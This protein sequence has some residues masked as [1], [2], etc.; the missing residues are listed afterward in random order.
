[1]TTD[2]YTHAHISKNNVLLRGYKDGKRYSK[3]IPYKPYMFMASN[4]RDAEFQTYNGLPAHKI[5]FDSIFEAKDFMRDNRGVAGMN[6][7]GMDRFIY[8]FLYDRFPGE[9]QYDAD[10]INVWF[11]DIETGGEGFPDIKTADHHVWAISWR[12]RDKIVALGCPP[13]GSGQDYRPRWIEGK[14]TPIEYISCA[15]ERELLETFLARW[16]DPLDGPDIVTGWNIE[17]FDIPYLVNRITNVLGNDEAKRLS[18]WR[19]L[20]EDEIES[21]GR[22]QQVYYPVGVNVLD[23]LNLY[24]KFTYNQQASYT[25]DHIAF[26][27]LGQRKLD[28]SEF[29]SLF[30][31]YKEDFNKAMEY[32]VKDTN[33]VYDIDQKMRLVELVYA[34]AYDAKVNY[35]DTLGAVNL[36][37]VIIHNYLRDRKMVVPQQYC[38]DND[39]RA[40]PG[41]FVKEPKPGMYNWPM[42]FDLTSLYPHLIMGYNISPDTFIR[43]LN[44]EF[45]VDDLVEGKH[46]PFDD[47]YDEK[48]SLT[49]NMCLYSNAKRGFL[50]ELMNLQ[51]VQRSEYKKKMLEAKK[52]YESTP[53]K[54]LKND[55]SRYDNAQMAKKIQ[56]NSAYGALANKYFRWYS[57][58][59][60]ESITLSGQLAARWIERKMNVYLNKVLETTDVD[61]VIAVDTDSIYLNLGDLVKKTMPKDSSKEDI[62]K[63]LDQV[64]K[65][66]IEGLMDKWYEE[67]HVYM[68]SYE[69]KMKMKRE[70]IAD[71]AIWTGK[72]RYIMNV[73]DNEGVRYAK[74]KLKIMGLESV[75]S[76]TPAAC[77]ERL[78][79]TIELIM[80]TDNDTV[81]DYIANFRQ[82][83]EK[84]PFDEI[85]FPRGINNIDKYY[86]PVT[87]C[88]KSCPMHVRGALVFNKLIADFKLLDKYQ[89]IVDKDKIKFAYLTLPN[90]AMQ[91]T[92][93]TP[94]H[95]PPEFE[96][97][98]SIDYEM[99]FNKAYLEPIRNIL[100]AIGWQTERFNTLEDLFG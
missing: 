80:N 23:Y 9:V 34:I 78:T 36:W 35:G 87:L 73:Y 22:Y 59:L 11:L 85:A 60:A 6:I 7:Y 93:A 42:S 71:K 13:P 1:M 91:N 53:T 8:P 57:I 52:Q 2:F 69:Q 49:A 18:P 99:Q 89:P 38:E 95:L 37:D 94:S 97:H 63:F 64:G 30:T 28:Y 56:L 51:F 86:D 70:A 41:G 82:E 25:L 55:I 68:N 40:V 65:K 16:N 27:E 19:I 33:L 48:A 47:Q 12:L 79:K 21:R 43:K 3:S 88:G 76:S 14:E 61:Y 20:K 29:S 46:I 31:L 24:K 77:R 83:F 75:R 98:D 50:N 100:D 5:E 58:D 44:T 15:T 62:V 39:D 81:I 45:N 32:N 96:L 67:L 17:F 4:D 90:K 26:V 72:K 92:I 54:Q 66:K 74:P 84:L 10:K